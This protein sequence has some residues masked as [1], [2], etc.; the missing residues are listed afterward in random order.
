MKFSCLS[1]AREEG[2]F[3]GELL[4]VAPDDRVQQSVKHAESHLI[5]AKVKILLLWS[6]MAEHL[7]Y[8]SFSHHI[9]PRQDIYARS[10]VPCNPNQ[11]MLV[12]QQKRG[13]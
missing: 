6:K 12:E 8:C 9:I 11:G 3:Q 13:L 1:V 7:F 4:A 2:R 10:A 5:R